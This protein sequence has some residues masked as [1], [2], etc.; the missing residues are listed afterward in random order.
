MALLAEI[1][2][3]ALGDTRT[4]PQR[5]HDALA[6]IAARALDGGGLGRHASVRPQVVVHVPLATLEAKAGT[7][8]L[9][10]GVVAG[11]PDPASPARSST[12]SSATPRSPAI[13]FGPRR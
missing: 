3:P 10:P 12:S 7:R 13:V 6:S 2:V 9:R 11:I 1:G 5:M 8:G 4:H